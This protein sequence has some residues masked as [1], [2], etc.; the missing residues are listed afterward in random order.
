VSRRALGA[1]EISR[2]RLIVDLARRRLMLR[3][4]GLVMLRAPAGVGRARWP[5]PR[6]TFLIR[7]RLERYVKPACGPV[8]FGTRARSPTLTDWPAAASSASTEPTGR[9]SYRAGCPTVACGCA[10]LTC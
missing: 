7:N 1:C 8:A 4:R 10:T 3:E 9:I 6:A 5:A 2:H